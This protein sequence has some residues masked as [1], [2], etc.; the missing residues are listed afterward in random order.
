MNDVFGV[1]GEGYLYYD[2]EIFD[3]WGNKMKFGRFKDNTAW[4][5]TYK[6]KLVPSGAYVYHVWVEPPIGIEVRETG[7][8]H[9]LSG[10]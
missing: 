4:D 9:V 3:R 2:L 8:L 1:E 6:G 10:E 7:L 5:G